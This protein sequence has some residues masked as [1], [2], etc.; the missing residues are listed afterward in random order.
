ML[1]LHLTTHLH[2]WHH[3]PQLLPRHKATVQR[4]DAGML[5]RL[6][7]QRTRSSNIAIQAAVSRYRE[8]LS[9]AAAAGC[10]NLVYLTAKASGHYAAACYAHAAASTPQSAICISPS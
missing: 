3:H 4:Q 5:V 2:V 8:A 9:M 10:A 1:Q 7:E 6:Q